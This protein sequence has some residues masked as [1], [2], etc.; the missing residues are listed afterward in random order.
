MGTS[1]ST[2]GKQASLQEPVRN[3]VVVVTGASSGLGL[4]TGKQLASSGAE[5]VMI[6]RDQTRGEQAQSQVAE[7]AAGKPPVLV[8]AELSVQ[9]D[10]RRVAEEVKARYHH[11]DVLINNAGGAFDSREQSADGIELT[12]ATNHIAPFLLTHLLLRLLV[13]APAGRVVNVTSEIYSRRLDVDNLQGERK[14]SYFGAYRTSK[15]GNVLFTTELARRVEGSGVTVVSVSPGPARTN[16]GG[17]GPSGVMGVVTG[18]MKRTPVFKPADQAAE[19]IVWAATA[20]EPE[21]TRGALYMRRKQLT[22]KGAATDPALAS[23][24]WSITEQQ[25]G[26]DPAR[27]AVAAV[28]AASRSNG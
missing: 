4:E 17:G 21:I 16:F 13:A 24:V 11:I 26:I 15:L 2:G 8:L 22:L 1:S 3:K 18:V 23:K 28:S 7:V 5:I 14:Y 6:C 12:W 27:S 9:A 10:V 20:P 19:G 25:A